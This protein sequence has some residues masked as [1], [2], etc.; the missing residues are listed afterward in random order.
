VSE[1]KSAFQIPITIKEVVEEVH[2]KKYLL[3]A[4]QREL[5]WDTD[6]II[7]LFDS[8]MR[9]YTIGSFLFWHVNKER[10]EDFQFYEFI[11]NFHER[12]NTHNPKANISGDED[13]TAILDG[14]QRFT[15]LY[16]GLKGSYSYKVQWKQWKSD[17]AF[18]TRKLYLNLL[19]ESPNSDQKYDFRFLTKE[20]VK[21]KD[22][23]IFWFEIGKVLE[24]KDLSDV[25]DFLIAND[26]TTKQ[27]EMARFA[28]KTLFKLFDAIHNEKIINFYLENSQELD[29][30]LNI[31]IRVNSGGTPLSYSDLLLSIATAQWKTK[32][33]REEINNFVDDI[34]GN[35]Q[36]DFERD[37]V[38][39]SC[40]VLSDITE[41]AFKVDNFNTKNMLTI[42]KKWESVMDSIRL[43]VDLVNSY[44]YNY[45][46]LVSANA[47]IP[48]AYYLSKINNPSTFV[49]SSK[50]RED[51][52]KIQKWL[53]ISLVKRSFSGQPDNVLR[54]IREILQKKHDVFP[55]DEL[56]TRFKG[57]PKSL[58]FTKD[59]IENLLDNEY[60]KK[61]T[62]ALISL[63][64][65]TLDFK[66]KFHQD[67][68]FPKSLFKI[69]KLEKLG[70]SK[71]KQESYLENYN[72]LANLQLLEGVPNEEKAA[73][74]FKLWLDKNFKNKK[75]KKEFMQKHHIP[76]NI[77]LSFTNFEEFLKERSKLL[78]DSFKKILST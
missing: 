58:V 37:F 19:T 15:A 26:L 46:T 43:T 1:K 29:K 36:F 76:D 9:D 27:K 12:D 64:Y 40:L 78:K 60:G 20:E 68:I 63:L 42:E 5:V 38:L 21:K 69:S 59:D 45:Q 44:G 16:L 51:R 55:F 73:K 22:E 7:K 10:L 25:N 13:V 49:Q 2:R 70:I 34:N 30:V 54:P 32:D 24:F 8:I 41:I 56:I 33:A 23:K 47:I 28:N 75:E 72:K 4:I 39:K 53:A 71:D 62:F 77:D 52:K 65:P 74:D 61:H 11:R 17:D 35:G 66:N 57:T 67:H 48:I 31:F 14:Q 18:P 6:Q 50:Y 3:P